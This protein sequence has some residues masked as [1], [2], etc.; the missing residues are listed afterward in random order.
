MDDAQRSPG[1]GWSR[2]A[3][4]D[5]GRAVDDTWWATDVS[6]GTPEPVVAAAPATDDDPWARVGQVRTPAAYRT[7]RAPACSV[8]ERSVFPTR[9]C[10]RG[11]TLRPAKSR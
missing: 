1:T 4:D 10:S 11:S 5:D 3:V 6:P 8:R 9:A 7:S 2:P